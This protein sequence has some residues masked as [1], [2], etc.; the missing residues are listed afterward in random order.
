MNKPRHG[1]Q[2]R[3]KAAVR[4]ARARFGQVLPGLIWCGWTGYGMAS[5]VSGAARRDSARSD[6]VRQGIWVKI[7]NKQNAA[8]LGL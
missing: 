5:N 3:G 4:C 1:A 6:K 7:L 8:S 2:R